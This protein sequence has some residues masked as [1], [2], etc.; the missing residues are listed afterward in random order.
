MEAIVFDRFGGPEVLRVAEVDVPQPG[1]GQIRLR[2]V[3]AGVN[4]VDH[5]I[6]NGWLAQVFTTT[7]PATP[8][9][10]AAGVVDE[11]GAGVTGL[12]AGDEVFGF[13]DTGSYAGFALA[14]VVARKP[15]GLGWDE[16]AALPVAGETAQRILDLLAVEKGETV[17]L[18]GA[19]GGVGGVAVQLAVARGATV[20]GTASPANHDYLRSL[21][22][23]P[24]AY[25]DGLAD[26]VRAAAPQGV[27]A[28]FD[29]AGQG[30]LE[31][32]V[33]VR[34]GTDRII[35]IADAVGAQR[36]GVPFSADGERGAEA[37]AALADLA[38]TG[39]LRVEVAGTFALAEAGKAQDRSATGHVRGKLI[40]HP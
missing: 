17:L 14:T 40:L 4:P 39:G 9:W 1:P 30:A 8:G 11:V 36:W 34:G 6:R 27:D 29:A 24:V 26:R 18:H 38:V 32:S 5:K 2:V 19:A 28:V 21:G 15:A 3:S 22:A 31:A 10:E 23:I 35:T 7:F 25:G 20:I 13:T 33:Q 37:L 16:A 12:A